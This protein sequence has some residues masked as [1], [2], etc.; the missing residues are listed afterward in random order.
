M[1]SNDS[2]KNTD[3]RSLAENAAFNMIRVGFTLLF[4]V[5]VFPY[6]SRRLGPSSLGSVDFAQS[7]VA[8]FAMIASMGIPAYGKIVCSRA[9]HS[10][11]ELKKTICE[12]LYLS[13]AL[14]IIAFGALVISI[15]AVSE[16]YRYRVLLMLNSVTILVSGI[17]VEWIFFALE[18]FSYTAVRAIAIKI[19]SLVL[20]FAMVRTPDDYIKYTF[21]NVFSVA[22][23][24]VMDFTLARNYIHFYRL[25]E[26]DIRRHIGPVMAFFASS[27]A[28]TINTNTDI[29]MLNFMKGEH[30]TGLYTFSGRIKSMLV[31]LMVAWLDAAI[32]RLSMLNKAG[33]TAGFRSLLRSVGVFTF[34]AG[35]AAAS[36]FI[37]F[38]GETVRILGG[39]EYLPAAGIVIALM[40]CMPVLAV[41]FILGYGVLLVS[42]REK[43]Y[44]RTMMITCLVNIAAN[45]ALIPILG[46]VGAALATLVSETGNMLLYSHFGKDCVGETFRDS[47]L[48][49]IAALSIIAGAVCWIGKELVLTTQPLLQMII[50]LIVYL[51]IYLPCAC[52]IST[53]AR[54]MVIRAAAG[55]RSRLKI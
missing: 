8:Y 15:F 22:A 16:L 48:L 26:L 50:F 32:P 47:H 41:N 3:S 39:T 13:F 35:C 18:R 7:V 23:T 5:V 27:V 40:L 42:E 9:R 29:V 12:L 49:R 44:A 11:E 37:V 43:Q 38:S 45:F 19:A 55:V 25:S 6:I 34:A 20:I 21:I 53:D 31:S 17:S 28:V 14:E 36:F 24:A 30:I 1:T 33:D 54:D 10:E 4:P 46:A 52:R 51:A 2:I